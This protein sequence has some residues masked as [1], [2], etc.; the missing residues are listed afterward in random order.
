MLNSNGRYDPCICTVHEAKVW[1][2]MSIQY[3]E[4]HHHSLRYLEPTYLWYCWE[5]EAKC[6]QPANFYLERVFGKQFE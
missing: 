1:L 5:T 4:Y 6:S 2:R 3:I